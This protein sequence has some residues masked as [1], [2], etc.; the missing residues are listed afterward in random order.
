MLHILAHNTFEE[1][2]IA[3]LAY[4]ELNQDLW[5]CNYKP[6]NHLNFNGIEEWKEYHIDK[7]TW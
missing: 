5:L 2:T 3:Q 7:G 1:K 4:I 6:T